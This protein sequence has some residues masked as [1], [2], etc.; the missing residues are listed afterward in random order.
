MFSVI[1]EPLHRLNLHT[2]NFTS[3]TTDTQAKDTTEITEPKHSED[4]I[5]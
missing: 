5:L 1:T 4:G 2:L 3:R